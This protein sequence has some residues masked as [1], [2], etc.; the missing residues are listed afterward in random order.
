M[1][2][3]HIRGMKTYRVTA[4]HLIPTD[5]FYIAETDDDGNEVIGIYRYSTRKAAEDAMGA[6]HA[7]QRRDDAGKG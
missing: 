6:I 7:R 5:G 2:L 1:A 3:W 4:S